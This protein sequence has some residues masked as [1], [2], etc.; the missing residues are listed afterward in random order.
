MEDPK[1]SLATQL[2]SSASVLD[3]PE[4]SKPWWEIPVDKD[5]L[6]SSQAD[7]AITLDLAP[8][9]IEASKAAWKEGQPTLL[10]NIL[11]VWLVSHSH[12]SNLTLTRFNSIAYVFCIHTLRLRSISNAPPHD[13]QMCAQIISQAVPFLTERRSFTRLANM[14]EAIEY[15]Q[16][17]LNQPIQEV[18]P[19]IPI[20]RLILD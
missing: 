16:S 19:I 1:S 2:L 7:L 15:V 14:D 17:R 18:C 9:L 11:S 3:G 5:A 4:S 6:I 12:E 8:S 13:R 10:F 20:K